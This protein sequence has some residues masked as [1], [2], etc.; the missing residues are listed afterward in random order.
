MPISQDPEKI[1]AKKIKAKRIAKAMIEGKPLEQLDREINSHVPDLHPEYG[2]Q[3]I[4]S[5][6]QSPIV[7][8]ELQEQL[9]RK[10]DIKTQLSNWKDRFDELLQTGKLEKGDVEEF[11]NVWA[12]YLKIAELHAKLEGNGN[13]EAT[14]QLKEGLKDKD[15]SDLSSM[16]TERLQ[17][18]KVYSAPSRVG[19]TPDSDNL[20]E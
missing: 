8:A 15:T 9:T 4:Y 12:I 2:R 19:E 20:T 3:R 13:N 11:K 1:T 10:V 6:L 7:Q 5:N 18:S 17:K 16:L 14:D